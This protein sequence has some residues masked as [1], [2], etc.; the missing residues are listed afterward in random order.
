[1]LLC[2]IRSCI[3]SLGTCLSVLVVAFM[4]GFFVKADKKRQY[5]VVSRWANFMLWWL[6]V[7]VGI[8]YK[9]EG[10]TD[11]P[12]GPMI[13]ISNHQSMWETF[14]FQVLFPRQCTVLKKELLNVPFFGWSLRLLD[15]IAIDRKAPVAAGE[16]LIEQ[17]VERLK[18]G[19]WVVIFPQGTRTPPGTSRPFARGG[20]TLAVTSGIPILPVAHNSGLFWRPKQFIKRPG[21]VHLVI[22]NPINPKGYEPKA[23]NN[24]VQHWIEERAQ[25]LIQKAKD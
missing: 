4:S 1:M 11:I 10:N 15:P 3:F 16:Q 21:T 23:L 7:S 14:T 13:L 25:R 19:C 8:N 9:L 6:K 20:A 22:G 5:W 17:G 2:F 12:A 24:E 18:R